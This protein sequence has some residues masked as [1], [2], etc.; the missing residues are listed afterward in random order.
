MFWLPLMVSRLS[1]RAD[2]RARDDADDQQEE[3]R[4]AG[5]E[6]GPEQHQHRLAERQHHDRHDQRRPEGPGHRLAG[7]GGELVRLAMGEGA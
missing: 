2:R 3:Q 6:A 7:E 1:A 5:V 4:I